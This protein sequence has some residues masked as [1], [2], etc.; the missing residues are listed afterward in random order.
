MHISAALKFIIE[1]YESSTAI[2]MKFSKVRTFQVPGA[3][4]KSYVFS[5]LLV[6][7]FLGISSRREKY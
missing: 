4:C 1:I 6:V 5:G 7:T 3:Y 2:I